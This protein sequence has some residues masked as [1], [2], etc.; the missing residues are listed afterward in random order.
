[1]EGLLSEEVI[2]WKWPTPLAE[3]ETPLAEGE[4]PLAEGETRRQLP[5]LRRQAKMG[6]K[7]I[8]VFVVREG[9]NE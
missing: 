4:T 8:E 6:R 1:M 3:G 7:E 5:K 2:S 9:R